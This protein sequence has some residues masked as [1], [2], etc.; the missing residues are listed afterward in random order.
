[1][2]YKYEDRIKGIAIATCCH[3][4]CKIEF[5]NNLGFYMNYCNFSIQEIVLLFKATSW[6][7][8]PKDTDSK[9]LKSNN[10]IFDIKGKSKSYFGLIS[11]YIVDF[12]RVFYLIDKKYKVFYLKYCDNEVTLEN[13]FILAIK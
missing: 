3:Q 4:I 1:M 7:F 8:G 2:N 10:D 11:K 9:I 12:A 13:N 5:L 6:I